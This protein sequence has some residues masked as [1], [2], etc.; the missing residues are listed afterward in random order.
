MTYF[1]DFAEAVETIKL[2]VNQF[3]DFLKTQ[4]RVTRHKGIISKYCDIAVDGTKVLITP[5][6]DKLHFTKRYARYLSRKFI[7][8]CNEGT[9]RNMFRVLQD[10]VEGYKLINCAIEDEEEQEW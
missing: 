5:K 2:D 3:V 8:T 4:V 1:V 9:Y 7:N 6:D 10:G